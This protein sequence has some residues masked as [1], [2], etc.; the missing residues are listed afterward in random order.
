MYAPASF[1]TKLCRKEHR[2]T[3]TQE[4]LN[5]TQ[6]HKGLNVFQLNT[7]NDGSTLLK[8]EEHTGTTCIHMSFIN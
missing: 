2:N 4:K 6:Q 8:R 1:E 3:E 7:T 5:A